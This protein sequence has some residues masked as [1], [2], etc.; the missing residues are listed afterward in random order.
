VEEGGKRGCR[1]EYRIE[2][3]KWADASGKVFGGNGILHWED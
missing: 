3:L 2:E 1:A